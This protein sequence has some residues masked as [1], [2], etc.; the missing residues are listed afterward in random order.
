MSNTKS[1]S[2]K[3]ALPLPNPHPVF[4]LPHRPPP[5]VPEIVFGESKTEQCHKDSCD[6]N[7]IVAGA[8]HNPAQLLDKTL[9]PDV[10]ADFS[11]TL[12]F[13]EMANKVCEAKSAFESL[14]SDVRS[15]FKNDPSKLIDFVMN[16]D[17]ALEAH[18][19]GLLELDEI[20]LEALKPK[21]DVKSPLTTQ[22][23][24]SEAPEPLEPQAN[25]TVTT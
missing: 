10:F 14:S 19:M 18:E 6:I 3:I 9:K 1:K 8:L 2:A 13:A 7:L 21:N 15:R 5:K 23:P 16:S 25:P 24:V 22:T 4:A 20:S 17:N 12:S 11:E